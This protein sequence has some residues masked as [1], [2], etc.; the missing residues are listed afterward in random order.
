MEG[1][2]GGH[3]VRLHRIQHA[4]RLMQIADEIDARASGAAIPCG[5][6][7]RCAECARHGTDEIDKSGS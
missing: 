1:L 5:R 3:A 7:K 4:L 6:D 2:C